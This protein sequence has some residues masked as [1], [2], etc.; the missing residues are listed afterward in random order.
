MA[1]PLNALVCAV[2]GTL[3]WSCVGLPI[4]Q[5]ILPRTLA[6]PAAPALGWAVHSALV[7]PIFLLI[8]FSKIT[9]LGAALLSLVLAIGTIRRSEQRDAAPPDAHAATCAC[10][11]AALL[12]VGVAVAIVPKA[13]GDGV[14]LAAPIFDHAKVA[15]IDE[16]TRLG[17]PPGDPFFGEASPFTRL[18]YYYLWHFSAAELALSIG[19]AEP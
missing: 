12:A 4:S 18:A 7:L 5:R 2:A 10:V 3:F 15:I 11:G 13:A 19:H 1:S 17:V 6:W 14:I 16:M 8:G 9:V